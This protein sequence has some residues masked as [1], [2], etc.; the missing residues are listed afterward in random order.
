[1]HLAAAAAV[2]QRIEW[3][4]SPT[5]GTGGG[6]LLPIDTALLEA[7]PEPT[8]S[9]LSLKVNSVLSLE[10]IDFQLDR[11]NEERRDGL[12]ESLQDQSQQGRQ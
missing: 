7:E 1:M 12:H 2:G 8:G 3:L 11:V 9:F 5:A 4:C 10:S 6:E